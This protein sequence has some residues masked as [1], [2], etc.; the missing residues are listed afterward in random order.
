MRL[1]PFA[2][3]RG[4]VGGHKTAFADVLDSLPVAVMACEPGEQRVVSANR[5]MRACLD[6]LAAHLGLSSSEVMNR[7][8]ADWLPGAET[9]AAMLS[10]PHDLPY[11]TELVIGPERFR[12]Q[13]SAIFDAG[14]RFCGAS[15]TWTPISRTADKPDPQDIAAPTAELAASAAA[16]RAGASSLCGTAE[17]ARE[18]TASLSTDAERLSDA[19]QSVDREVSRSLDLAGGA[20]QNAKTSAAAI[21][22]LEDSAGRIADLVARVRDI[23]EQ[24]NLLAINATIEASR[25]GESGRGFASMAREVKA[26]SDQAGNATDEIGGLVRSIRE[27]TG[28]ATEDL[29]ATSRSIDG[30]KDAAGSL[31]QVAGDQQGATRMLA[32][33]VQTVSQASN[34]TGRIAHEVSRSA[35]GLAARI[36]RLQAV[37]ESSSPPDQAS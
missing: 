19:A 18:M 20:A 13:G 6:G 2:E 7:R 10:H 31:S 9:L 15:L 14:G 3:T 36:E 30:M 24:T 16:I 25:V 22:A 32:A 29:A 4:L 8:L 37:V 28:R 35:Q 21:S 1:K 23:A 27:A 33:R 17:R 34:E 5:A 11:G 26:L 12:V